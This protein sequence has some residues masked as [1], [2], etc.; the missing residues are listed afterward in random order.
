MKK[1]SPIR[2]RLIVAANKKLFGERT[3][4]R[5]HSVVMKAIREALKVG[6]DVSNEKALL[7]FMGRKV[8]GDIKNQISR[9]WALRRQGVRHPRKKAKGT[10]I[11]EWIK[12]RTTQTIDPNLPGFLSSFEWRRLRMVVL[13]KRGARCEC[14]GRTPSDGIKICVDHIKPRSMFPELALVESNLQVLCDDCNHGK[15]SLFQTDWR[16]GKQPN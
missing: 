1:N 8:L 9:E 7:E 15:G 2:R 14:C 11:V 12:T 5:K 10:M 3:V 16:D 6:A 13:E 4:M